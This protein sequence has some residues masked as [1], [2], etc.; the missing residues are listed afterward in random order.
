MGKIVITE[1]GDD[2]I[3]FMGF[4]MALVI[5]LALMVVCMPVSRP[6]LVAI[7]RVA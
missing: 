2:G 3:D 1:S 4:L 7:H 5:A 6:R